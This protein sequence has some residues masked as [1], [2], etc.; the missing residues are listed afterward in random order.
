VSN[1]QIDIWTIK[2]LADVVCRAIALDLHII[3]A[4]LPSVT[5]PIFL[6]ARFIQHITVIMYCTSYVRLAFYG[7]SG[8]VQTFCLGV[9]C[10]LV[11]RNSALYYFWR[12]Y[13]F[14]VTKYN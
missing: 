4:A 11:D 10:V 9:L 13:L 12:F 3:A 1:V 8:L 14:P 7:L 6:D 5:E 2:S